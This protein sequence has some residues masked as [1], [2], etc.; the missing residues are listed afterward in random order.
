MG[1]TDKFGLAFFDYG[2]VLT[3]NVNI[4][5]EISRFVFIDRQLYGM[6]SVFGDGIVSG[7]EILDG[8]DL[9]ITINPGVGVYEKKVMESSFPDI[10]EDL[11]P[12][13]LYYVY[14]TPGFNVEFDK[15]INFSATIEEQFNGIF[16]GTVQTGT[17]N[18]EAIDISTR[19]L[20]GFK[21]V[22]ADE[23]ALHRH[24]G[25][26]PKIDLTNEVQ[27][28]LPTSRMEDIDASKITEGRIPEKVYPRINHT[29]LKNT[30]KLTHPQIDSLISSMQ[31]NNIGLFGEVETINLMKLI[32]AQK[33]YNS[34]I[35][36]YLINQLAIIPGISPSSYIDWENSN[37]II[38]VNNN[39]ISGIPEVPIEISSNLPANEDDNTRNIYEIININW[40][41]D[42]K[43]RN[44]STSKTNV[45]IN[46]G[47]RLSV[48]TVSDKIIEDFEGIAGNTV[49]NYVPTLVNNNTTKVIYSSTHTQGDTAAQF[50]TSNSRNV[51]FAKSFGQ[52]QDWSA[53]DELIIFVK[54]LTETHSTVTLYLYDSQEVVIGTY[55]ILNADEQTVDEDGLSGF[56]KK[57]IDISNIERNDVMKIALTTS[58][59]TNSTETFFIDT[60]FLRSN[61]FLLPQGNIKFRKSTTSPVIF[62]AIEYNATVPVGCDLRV[63]YRVANTLEELVNATYSSNLQSGEAFAVSGSHLEI[64]VILVANSEKTLSPTLNNLTLQILA[65]SS[66]EGLEIRNAETW[67]KGENLINISVNDEINNTYVYM[68]NTNVNDFY[69]INENQVTELDPDGFPVVGINSQY[70]PISP[71][72]AYNVINPPTTDNDPYGVRRSDTRGLYKPLSS[73]RLDSGNYI[74]ADTYNDRVMEITQEGTFVRGWASHNNDYDDTDLYALTANYNPRLGVLFITLSKPTDI[75]NFDLTII[76]L[77][78]GGTREIRLSNELDLVRYTDGTIVTD[79]SPGGTSTTTDNLIGDVDRTLTVLLSAEKRDILDN[80]TLGVQCAISTDIQDQIDCFLGDYM[81]FGSFGIHRPIYANMSSVENVIIANASILSESSSVIKTFP[82]IEFSIRIGELTEGQS[83]PLGLTYSYDKMLFSDIMIGSLQ[84]IENLTFD[85]EIERKLLIAGVVYDPSISVDSSSSSSQ[86]GDVYSLTL[87]DLDDKKMLPFKGVVRMIDMT[88]QLVNFEYIS[89]DGLYPSDAYIDNDGNVV[90]AESSFIAQTGRIVTL[91]IAGMADG[92]QPPILKL[93]EGGMF[94]KVWD[95]RQLKENHVFVST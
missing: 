1:Q 31:K 92:R 46:N 73:Y 47:I 28:Q 9:N 14:A 75:R 20:V 19:T 84:V 51:N 61:E 12:N 25:T 82:V 72:Q 59:I 15:S 87:P 57:Q 91:D 24:N 37:A 65:P 23:I 41:D 34:N 63:R 30:G 62:N 43:F 74:I 89:S 4:Q 71:Q 35:D 85:G 2:E 77:V 64:D 70:M 22:V 56:A 44:E 69:F 76:R 81:Y 16:L 8:G 78:I 38:D 58:T 80:T 21:Q 86:A 18:I 83:L 7:W 17:T 88:S 55:I 5:K 52:P 54:N 49:P 48:D 10:V 13:A 60:I 40:D 11:L 68:K 32:L 67:N 42:T 3:D 45:A 93:I 53:Y 50:Q 36:Q 79:R 27:G 26:T 39:C 90:V 29:N 66:V 94:T 6:A 33:Y 95:I